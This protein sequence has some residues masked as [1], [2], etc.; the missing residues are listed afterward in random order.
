MRDS[1]VSDRGNDAIDRLDEVASLL[2]ASLQQSKALNSQIHEDV[3]RWK[4]DSAAESSERTENDAGVFQLLKEI[5]GG[6]T[7][8]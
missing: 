8:Q 2:M 1:D 6:T 4:Q 7:S 3:L 5:I